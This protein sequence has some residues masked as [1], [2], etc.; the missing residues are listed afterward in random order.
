MQRCKALFEKL[1][2]ATC[3]ANVGIRLTN[4][5]LIW[6]G[7]PK[8]LKSLDNATLRVNARLQVGHFGWDRLL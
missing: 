3:I 6:S 2:S 4:H 5:I 1:D 7:T 8:C